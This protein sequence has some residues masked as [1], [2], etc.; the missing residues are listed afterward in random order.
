[1]KYIFI[2]TILFSLSFLSCENKFEPPKT[3]YKAGEIPD[4]ESWNST[5][6]FSDSGKVKAVLKAGHISQFNAQGLTLIDSG[7]V[8][9]FYKDGEVVSTLTGKKGRVVDPDKDIEMT[10]SVTVVSKDGSVLKT[11]KMYWHNKTQKV[12]SDAYVHI[13]TPKEEIQGIG[14][15]SDQNLKN[16]TIFK[17][18]GIFSQ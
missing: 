11:P 14:F 15:E 4:Q 1:M 8:V 12:T 5:V 9:D 3:N 7:G 16:Y 13:K 2:L 18:I 6:I 17:P 10:D